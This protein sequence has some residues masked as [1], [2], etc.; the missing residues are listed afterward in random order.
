M[1]SE[2]EKIILKNFGQHLKNLKEKQKLSYREFYK[3]SGVNTGDI[4]KYENGETSPTF[5][6]LTR[7]AIGL[8]THPSVLLDF[9][10]EVDFSA[11]LE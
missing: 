10:F 11:G 1:I 6:T 7:L 4:I 2:K 8:K 9:D 5:I 3:R